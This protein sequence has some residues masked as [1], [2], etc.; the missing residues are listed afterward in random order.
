LILRFPAPLDHAL[1]L[2][3]IH[4]IGAGEQRV[5]GRSELDQR[6]S[7]WLFAPSSIWTP[8]SYQLRIDARLE[9]VCGNTVRAPFDV[10]ARGDTAWHGAEAPTKMS[11]AGAIW[12]TIWGLLR[13]QAAYA[14]YHVGVALDQEW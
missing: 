2:R 6:E 12:Y 14:V 4:V 1:L 10:N 11:I 5:T 7:Q 9:D 3:M 13:R 8:G